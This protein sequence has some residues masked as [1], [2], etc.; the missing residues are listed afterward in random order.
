VDPVEV[1][2]DAVHYLTARWALDSGCE[3]LI[4]GDGGDGVSLGYAF[5][6]ELS[7]EELLEWHRA[8]LEEA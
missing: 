2:A 4:S 1:S 7:L 6:E 5:L 3:C 8:V